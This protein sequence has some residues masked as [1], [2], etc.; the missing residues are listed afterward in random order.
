MQHTITTRAIVDT[1]KSYQYILDSRDRLKM[2]STEEIVFADP[3]LLFQEH[4]L[5]YS[6]TINIV[7]GKSGVHKSRIV[8]AICACFLSRDRDNPGNYIGFCQGTRSRKKVLYVDT[9]R[10]ER[11]QFPYAIQQIKKLAGYHIRDQIPNFDFFSL[12]QVPRAE[13]HLVLQQ[14]LLHELQSDPDTETLVVLDVVTD[15]VENF[16][17]AQGSMALTDFLNQQ[18]SHRNVTFICV[19]HE[20]PGVGDKARGHL[21]TELMNKASSVLQIGFEKDASGKDSELIKVSILKNRVQARQQPV[22]MRFD[23]HL[24]AL[25]LAEHELIQDVADSKRTAL[26][27]TELLEYLCQELTSPVASNELVARVMQHFGC[28]KTTVR[29]RLKEL[30]Y[31][32]TTQLINAN[33]QG[34]RLEKNRKGKNEFYSIVYPREE[35]PQ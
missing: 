24:R 30:V 31:K 13:R 14:Y 9:E 19:I 23:A 4:G 10:N 26:S 34:P 1:V 29:D 18:I 22:Y 33:M 8:E 20:N 21:G 2:R 5:I 27:E 32:G 11:D 15:C 12:I 16:N 7:Q 17:D 3:V 6:N 25:I 35:S 28:S